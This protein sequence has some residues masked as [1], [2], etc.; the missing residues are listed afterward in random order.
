MAFKKGVSGN[1][2]GRPPKKK[3]IKKFLQ[4]R[5]S[6]IGKDPLK[7][8]RAIMQSYNAE[9]NREMALKAASIVL[10]YDE[11]AFKRKEN[12]DNT[13]RQIICTW[14]APDDIPEDHPMIKV[15]KDREDNAE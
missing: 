5:A 14:I 1:P 7:T 9:G 11:A 4:D 2:N 10:P 6:E 8:V 13:I 15:I 3:I 12:E